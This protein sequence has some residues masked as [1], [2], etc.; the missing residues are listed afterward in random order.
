MA[1]VTCFTPFV[2]NILH[3]GPSKQQGSGECL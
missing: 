1:T 2:T 3:V